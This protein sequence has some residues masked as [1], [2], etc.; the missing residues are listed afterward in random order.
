M[1]NSTQIASMV[2]TGR[3][4]HTAVS[5]D[6]ALGLLAQLPGTWKNLPDL[7]GR[8]W[9]MIALPFAG[10]SPFHFRLLVNQ[11]NEELAFTLVDKGVP[12]R[13]IASSGG[14]VTESD[15]ILAAL[16]YV[17]QIVQIAGADFPPSKLVATNGSPIH[18]EPGLWLHLAN[19]VEP[20][21][22][23]LVRMG[24]IP[25]GDSILALGKGQ[26]APG[27]PVIPVI[28]GLPIGE[29]PDL[30]HNPYLAPY[31][32]FHDAPFQGVFDPTVPN[33][34]LAQ[35]N[36]GVKIVRTTTIEVDTATPT[37]GIVN[38]PFVVKQ[39]NPTE[40]KFT[41][42]IQELA[43]LDHTGQPKLRLQYSQVV[44]LEFFPR[45]D[46]HKGLIRWPHVSIN[47]LEKIV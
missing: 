19:Q 18:H 34:L 25:H 38:I 35:A 2:A 27:A 16:Q 15:Q 3:V 11:F 6:P 13:G 33:A 24:T 26:V 46:G 14:A 5:G 10:N 28:S 42:W 4:I 40:M 12:N 7:P 17:Q 44:F 1:L 37:G 22:S 30:N 21:G 41:L 32:H 36:S 47:T 31:K 39:A 20:G 45:R 29:N 9:N 23:Y 43:D 8:G